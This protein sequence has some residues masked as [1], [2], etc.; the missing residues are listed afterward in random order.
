VADRPDST[1]TIAPAGDRQTAFHRVLCGVDGSPSAL[2]AVRQAA[3]LASPGGTLDLVCVRDALGSGRSAQAT[4]SEWRAD[5]ALLEAADTA[6]EVGVGCSQEVI[7][8]K[9]R[10]RA[11][12]ERIDDHDLVVVGPHLRS[13][14]GGILVGSTASALLHESPIPVL[15]ARGSKEV[16]WTPRTIL[17]ASDGSA[18]SDAAVGL[19]ARIGAA[20]GS[21]LLLVSVEDGHAGPELRKT[22]ARQAAVLR[23]AGG[24]EIPVLTPEGKAE[25]EIVGAADHHGATLIVIGSR[26]MSGLK[27]LGSVSERVAHRARCSVLVARASG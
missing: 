8:A 5:A 11:L 12:I 6:R 14:V 24:S 3:V 9:R 4:I 1:Q 22:L 7:S 26:G 23:E 21:H 17:V 18:R 15:A 19:A 10:A 27:A 20:H 16:E 2:E 25:E 13:R